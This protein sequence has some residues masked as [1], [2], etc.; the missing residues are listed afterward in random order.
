MNQQRDKL[1]IDG[2]WALP[3]GSE[4]IDVIDPS[5]EQA[6]GGVPLGDARDV[7]AA[8]RAAR[9]AFPAW[10]SLPVAARAELLKAISAGLAARAEELGELMSREIGM[11]RQQSID[12]Q[13]GLPVGTFAD[14]AASVL[15]MEFEQTIDN[16]LVV[17]EPVGVVGAITPWN[18]PL[19]QIAAKVA[20]ALAVGCTVVLKPSEL[21]PLNAFALAE[22]IEQAGVPA[23]VFNLVTGTGPVAGEAIAA[24]PEVDMVSFTGSTLAGQR[25]SELAAPGI[26][27]VT[28]ELGGKSPNILLDDAPFEEAVP[29]GVA[30]AYL[31][32]GQSCSAHTR[33]VV[34]RAEL[35]R[36]EELARQT[37]E[38]F[39]V[40]DPADPDTKLGP[41]VSERQLARVR[42]YIERGISEGAKL[43]TGGAAPP[44]G[45]ARGYFVQPT[46]FS[47][48]DNSSTIAQEEIFG[49]VL[50]II[51]YDSE[52][53][54]IRIA[55]ESRYGLAG[56]VWSSDRERALR[57]ARQLHTGQ[58]DINGGAFNPRAPF[59]GYKQSGNGRELG[60]LALEEFVET[61]ALNL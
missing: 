56:G 36:V 46:V 4:A 26:K 38:E 37:A 11:P 55:N 3:H 54:A 25:V 20:P 29:R 27:R 50:S 6:I 21:A 1:F 8:V 43:V 60:P 51:P 15:A 34:P 40:G 30:A 45:Q 10:A 7:D 19:H 22:V 24:H 13:L 35:E 18:F 58:V 49:P 42:D 16:S 39:R 32:S 53:D 31:N 48:V 5:T 61:K 33:M 9:A 28:L 2:R 57:V 47:E 14:T 59:G 41:V 17:H 52:A 12:I 44:D 23:G